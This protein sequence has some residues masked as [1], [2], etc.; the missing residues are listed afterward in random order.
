MATKKV[1]IKVTLDSGAS[2]PTKAHT[3]DTGYDLKIMDVRLTSEIPYTYTVL[4]P[5]EHH[6]ESIFSSLFR[7][8]AGL[9]FVSHVMKPTVAIVDTGVHVQPESGYWTMVVPN[10]R[11]GKRPFWLGNCVGIIDQD[12][13]GSIKL[14]YKVAPWAT[15]EQVNDFFKEGAVCGQLIPMKRYDADFG[16]VN[17]LNTTERG[18]GGF[19]STEKK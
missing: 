14:I 17:E 1:K 5:N 18:D 15:Y 13:T 4:H 10:S 7:A 8:I 19:G 12:Y 9:P 3:T 16:V 11:S 6:K 2:L